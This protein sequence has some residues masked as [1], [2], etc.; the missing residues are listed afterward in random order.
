MRTRDLIIALAAGIWFLLSAGPAGAAYF[1]NPVSTAEWDLIGGE[2]FGD[3]FPIGSEVA[4]WDQSGVLRFRADVDNL[5]NF[6]GLAAFY[7]PPIGS[8]D[9]HDF[10]WQVYDG[11]SVY[12]AMVHDAG[13]TWV[14]YIGGTPGGTF[15][16]NLDRGDPP[17]PPTVIP[18]PATVLVIALL[19]GSGAVAGIRKRFHRPS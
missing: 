19:A 18:E 1:P 7:G 6:F 2:I 14:N 17:D 11:T 16:L 15:I 13:T 4:A 8:T 3:V 12:T 9:P 10:T 5:A